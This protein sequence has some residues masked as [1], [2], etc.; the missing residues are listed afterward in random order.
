MAKLVPTGRASVLQSIRQAAEALE[1]GQVD[2]A[3][4]GAADSWVSP[5][6]LMWLRNNGK[7]AEYPRRTGTMPGEAAGFLAL[8]KPD[9]A[10]ARKARIYALVSASAG[11]HEPAPYGEPT[12][13]LALTQ[14]IQSVFG[15][16]NDEHLLMI[17]DQNGERYRALEWVLAEPKA[18]NY[19]DT[20][21]WLTPAD[22]IGDIG[23]ASGSVT[24]GWAATALARG[25]AGVNNVLVWGTSDEGAREAVRLQPAGGHA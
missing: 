18:L 1:S 21:D 20:L 19:F 2:V 25:Y 9:Q 13:A 7:L 8:E 16:V 17:T 23:A 24:L 3:I 5:R 11:R 22:C 12:H 15:D 10:R 14:S 6:S 4:I